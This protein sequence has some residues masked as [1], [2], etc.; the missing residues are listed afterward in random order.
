MH[1]H[2]FL[3]QIPEDKVEVSSLG[4]GGSSGSGGGGV[5]PFSPSSSSPRWTPGS[6]SSDDVIGRPSGSATPPGPGGSSKSRQH[7]QRMSDLT[8]VASTVS[9]CV[10]MHVHVHVH[11]HVYVHVYTCTCKVQLIL[12][13]FFYSL[14]MH[15]QSN[16]V[17]CTCA[18]TSVHARCEYPTR[19][20]FSFFYPGISSS[21]LL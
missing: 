7:S 9:L 4:L 16:S 2:F 13:K 10:Y 21:E 12:K 18:M 6:A 8:T 3:L 19:K 20:D 11:V 17:L 1:V 15:V 14:Q 5:V